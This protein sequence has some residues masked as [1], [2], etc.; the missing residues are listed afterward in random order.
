MWQESESNRNIRSQCRARNARSWEWEVIRQSLSFFFFSLSYLTT[1]T[2]ASKSWQKT[3]LFTTTRGKETRAWSRPE[4]LWRLPRR[5]LS[6]CNFVCKVLACISHFYHH[7]ERSAP[8]ALSVC[9][10]THCLDTWQV[11]AGCRAGHRWVVESYH[12]P[13]PGV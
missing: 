5:H 13:V 12:R 8:V 1:S 2:P 11:A 4:N 7:R 6:H 10:K 9:L 3:L